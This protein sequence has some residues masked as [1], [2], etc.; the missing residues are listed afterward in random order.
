M[1]K[2]QLSGELLNITVTALLL[3]LLW[4][5]LAQAEFAVH[6]QIAGTGR[7]SLAPGTVALGLTDQVITARR[8][9]TSADQATTFDLQLGQLEAA[10]GGTEQQDAAQ[11]LSA[12]QQAITE[13][14]V[15][16][17]LTP[18]GTSRLILGH[19]CRGYDLSVYVYSESFS[20]RAP[21]ASVKGQ[22]WIA[23]NV[24]GEA[25]WSDAIMSLADAGA[26]ISSLEGTRREPE[27]ARAL[28]LA[29]LTMVGAGTP[30]EGNLRI[31]QAGRALGSRIAATLSENIRFTATLAADN[32]DEL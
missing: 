19:R 14:R 32:S 22:V 26:T 6:Y 17:T 29:A 3:S 10:T 5:S 24:P 8:P 16:A 30:L 21:D 25:A 28:M 9:R 15:S 4:S 1:R 27:R 20:A 23:S 13:D 12:A 11:R 31:E 7:D 2:L 18:A